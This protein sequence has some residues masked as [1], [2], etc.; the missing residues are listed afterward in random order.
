MESE[1]DVYHQLSAYTL[2]RGDATF[3]HQHVV[4]AFAAQRADGGTKPIKIAFSLAGL[5]LHVEQGYSGRQVQLAH[6]QLA[7][8]KRTWPTFVLPLHRGAMTVFEVMAQ[9]PGAERDGA[10]H[11]WSVSV[12][13]AFAGNRD[14]MVEFLRPYGLV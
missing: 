10:I 7:R 8:R 13:D 1:E 3:I 6:M 4:D 14:A 12:W 9:P 5:Y 11:D 2:Q